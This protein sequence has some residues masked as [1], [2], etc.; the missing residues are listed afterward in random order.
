MPKNSTKIILLLLLF[1]S[2]IFVFWALANNL[3]FPDTDWVLAK[4]EK[5]PLDGKDRLLQKFVASRD[6]LKRVELFFGKANLRPG[7][8]ITLQVLDENCSGVLRES[9]LNPSSVDAD[10]S[11]IFSFSKIPDSKNQIFCLKP[12]FLPEKGVKKSPS[13]FINENPP[14]QN[15]SLTSTAT[16][17]EWTNRSLAMRPGYQNDN[18]F[19]NI[20]ELNQRISQ[21]KPWFLKHYYLYFITFSFILLSILLATLLILI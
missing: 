7:G 16:N 3:A 10:N 12:N 4:G 14:A 1:F 17:E 2:F 8:K 13:L 6:N 9:S 11:Y 5:I 20:E 19:Q 21:Y 15:I 18:W